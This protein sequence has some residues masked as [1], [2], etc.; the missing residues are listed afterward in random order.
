MG[1][2][3]VELDDILEKKFRKL[4]IDVIGV[5]KG[6]LGTA[7]E[8]AIKLWVD[9]AKRRKKGEPTD[10]DNIEPET[11]TQIDQELLKEQTESDVP[12]IKKSKKVIVEDEPTADMTPV[13]STEPPISERSF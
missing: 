2:I 5:G 10:L 12:H 11:P 8:E 3:V 7:V 6:S 4:I 13:Y 1:R 9:D